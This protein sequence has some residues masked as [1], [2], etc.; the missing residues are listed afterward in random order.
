MQE[1]NRSTREKPA[2]ASLDWKTNGH[3]APEPG[4]ELG[5]SGPQREGNTAMLPASPVQ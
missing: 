4:V 3:T 1:Q 2:E 5:L